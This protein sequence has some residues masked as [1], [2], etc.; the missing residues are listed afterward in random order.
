MM[1]NMAAIQSAAEISDLLAR[2]TGMEI[3]ELQVLGINSLKSLSPRLNAL[4]GQTVTGSEVAVRV[5]TIRTTDYQIVID[6]QRTGR[7]VWL[8]RAQ[9]YQ[10]I[11]GASRPTVRLLLSGGIGL[12]ASEPA[13]TK[14]ITVA[15]SPITE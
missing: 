8:T 9:L 3:S 1:T 10:V 15:L 5:V 4:S 12:D 14:R 6:L 2:V 7:L 11:A 13:K